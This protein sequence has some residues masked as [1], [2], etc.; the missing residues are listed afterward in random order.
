[1]HKPRSLSTISIRV[2]YAHQHMYSWL[3]E[4]HIRKVYYSVR[5]YTELTCAIQHSSR[6]RRRLHWKNK[7]AGASSTLVLARLY[8]HVSLARTRVHK[9][10][11]RRGGPAG[12]DSSAL[13]SPHGVS[14]EARA[15]CYSYL[16]LHTNTLHELILQSKKYLT[17]ILMRTTDDSFIST[18]SKMF[19]RQ[20]AKE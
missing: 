16:T 14:I 4:T 1:M 2:Q 11:S 17:S 8:S 6:S 5:M 18:T 19:C 12:G 10:A 9:D 20:G 3:K 7:T 13:D 15:G